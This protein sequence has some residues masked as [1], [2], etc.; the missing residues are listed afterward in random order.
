MDMDIIC[1]VCGFSKTVQ[2]DKVP[3]GARWAVCPN[4]RHRFELPPVVKPVP[5]QNGGTP[6]ERREDIGLWQGIY[7]TF[8]TVLF[9]PS[10]FFREI[11]PDGGM[12]EPLSFGLLL[13][14][15]GY[16]AGFF[17]KFLLVSMGVTSLSNGF[18]SSIPVSWLFLIGMISSPILVILNMFLVGAV[19]HVL[20]LA[21]N[22]GKG[23]FNG[24]LKVIAY[25]QAAK[26]LAFIPFIGGGIGWFWN[27]AVIIPGL[28]EIHKTSYVKAAAAV[29]IPLILLA[30]IIMSLIL[31]T[32]LLKTIGL[33]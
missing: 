20:M 17:W 10:G 32:S 19:V 9:S 14:S 22:A 16:M 24:T 23:G 7:R 6:W 1:P 25:G 30:V 27:I 31:L 28:K 29:I 33:Q 12:K 3:E 26:A 15:L 5:T 18:L 13:G 21:F 2:T 4:C 11:T 8:M